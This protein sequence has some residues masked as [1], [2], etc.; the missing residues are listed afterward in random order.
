M[1]AAFQFEIVRLL[2]QVVGL[3]A[4]SVGLS[5]AIIATMQLPQTSAHLEMWP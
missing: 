4:R 1:R 2:I 3:T 5:V